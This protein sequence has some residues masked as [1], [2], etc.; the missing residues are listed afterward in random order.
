MKRIVKPVAY[1]LAVLAFLVGCGSMP[2]TAPTPTTIPA[3]LAPGGNEA[4]PG[5]PET[6]A[7]TF[8]DLADRVALA[9]PMVQ[10]YRVTFTGAAPGIPVAAAT[11][12][13]PPAATP[14]WNTL[15]A[16]LK[17]AADRAF[18][19]ATSTLPTCVSS[20]RSKYTRSPAMSTIAT[21]IVQPF[22]RASAI[23][24][25]ATFLAVSTL[26]DVP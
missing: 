2:E 22:F 20:I 12:V 17:R 6:T 3:T 5:T 10:S 11:P 8:G 18:A 21:A 13:T 4:T 1:T 9:W 19:I 7:L 26:R 16:R 14:S 24:G 15:V 25:A 23:A